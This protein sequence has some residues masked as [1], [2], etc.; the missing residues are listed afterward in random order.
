MDGLTGGGN[1]GLSVVEYGLEE[2]EEWIES[3][4]EVAPDLGGVEKEEEG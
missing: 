3:L 1:Q 4:E 2:G